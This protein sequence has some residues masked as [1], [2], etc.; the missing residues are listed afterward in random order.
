MSDELQQLELEIAKVRLAKEE[1]ELRAAIL[2]EERLRKMGAGAEKSIDFGNSAG[3][4]S[5]PAIAKHAEG[6]P[7]REVKIVIYYAVAIAILYGLLYLELWKIESP[8][9][10]SLIVAALILS[11]ALG[12]FATILLLNSASSHRSS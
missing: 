8:W 2:R 7:N 6:K 12:L 1:S 5:T 3:M 10:I 9:E 4:D 11:G